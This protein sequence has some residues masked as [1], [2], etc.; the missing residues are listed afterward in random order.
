MPGLGGTETILLVEDEEGVRG[1]T[2]Q[3]LQRHGHT[4][5][6]AEHGQDALLLCERYSGPIHLLLTDVVLAQMSGRELVGRLAPMRPTMRVLYMSGY[7]DEAI[8]Q[9]G[10]L[11]PGTAF[12][13][14]PFTTESLMRRIREV[15]DHKK[16][17]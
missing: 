9:H 13:Q 12:L 15:L 17:G 14:K 11:A 5:L 4:V 2:R 10:V 6:E 16:I 7:S 8:V 3:L 1:L